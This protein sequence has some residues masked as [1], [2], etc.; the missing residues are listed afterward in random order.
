M[1]ASRFTAVLA[2]VLLVGCASSTSPPPSAPHA[3]V[4]PTRGASP[5][6]AEA[7]STPDEVPTPTPAETPWPMAA[8]CGPGEAWILGYEETDVACLD[9]RGWKVPF[10]GFEGVRDIAACA[11]GTTWITTGDSVTWTDGT[12]WTIL[13]P[14]YMLETTEYTSYASVACDP[15]GGLWMA[16][17]RMLAYT[18]GSTLVTHPLADAPNPNAGE[19]RDLAVAPNGDAWVTTENDVLVFDGAKWT[20]FAKSKG[21][22]KDQNYSMLVLDGQGHAW[23]DISHDGLRRYDGKRWTVYSQ[24][25]PDNIESLAVDRKGRLWVG[26]M[27]SGL[28]V[29]DG[30]RWV[31][32]NQANS[33]LPSDRVQLLA[34]DDRGRIW[35][36][37]DWGLA[38]LDG[39][40]WHVYHEA[41]SGIPGNWID[42]LA[43]AGRGPE[44]PALMKKQPG[45]I[46]GRVVS[47]GTPVAGLDVEACDPPV[48]FIFSGPTPCTERPFHKA[49]KT[50][51][52]GAFTFKSIPVGTY[53]IVVQSAD[54]T[55]IR[56]VDPDFSLGSREMK[57]G[58]GATVDFGVIDIA[59]VE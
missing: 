20:S 45:T 7:A 2:A 40:S 24:G 15:K 57:V 3:T 32:Y 27:L 50:D 37:T 8:N 12:V 1:A 43:V 4:P 11:D 5:S 41:D 6:A 38:V 33:D 44:T 30:H 35:I 51:R 14:Q 59:H 29:F 10:A 16:G 48:S 19:V 25:V 55:W 42:F 28:S 17:T 49:T 53:S 31:T 39:S 22:K 18:D 46:T 54:G 52:G 13:Y 36:G 47:S 9:A 58:E 23:A 34:V 26:T 56:L 21:F